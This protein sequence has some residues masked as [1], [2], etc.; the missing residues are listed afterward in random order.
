MSTVVD[1]TK[2]LVPAVASTGRDI[3]EWGPENP[4]F[5]E[6]T[7]RLVACRNLVLSVVPSTS[8]SACGACGR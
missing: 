6:T 4:E 1:N 2:E 8:D 3:A 5:W 7:G